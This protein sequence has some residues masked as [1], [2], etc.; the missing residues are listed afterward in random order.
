VRSGHAVI[1]PAVTHLSDLRNVGP[2]ALG[3]FAVLG[4][5]TVAQLATCEPADLFVNLQRLTGKRQDPCVYDVF[6]A[7]IHQAQT[8]EAKNWWAFTG[9]R[10]ALQ[11]AGVFPFDSEG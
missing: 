11:K 2:A 1:R 10:K 3:D 5:E 9:A 8:G 6:A 4:V 7:V